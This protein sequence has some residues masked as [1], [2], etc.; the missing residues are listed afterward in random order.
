MKPHLVLLFLVTCAARALAQDAVSPD[1]TARF[2]AGLPVR[3]T[4]LEGLSRNPSWVDHAAEFDKAWKELDTRQL[5]KI[6]A[7]STEFLTDAATD[8]GPMFYMFSGPDILYAQVF[9]PNAS[10]YVLA[11]LEPVGTVPDVLHLPPGALSSGLANLRKSMNSVLSFSFFI[12]KDMKVDLHQNQLSGTLPILYVFLE[13]AGCKLDSVDLVWLDKTGTLSTTKASTPGVKIV[14]FGPSGAQQ[15]L[16]YF[17]TNLANE[18]VKAQPGFLKFCENLAPGRSLLKAASYLMHL[19]DFTTVRDFLLAHS[20]MIV[21]DDSGI[22]IK[23]FDAAKWS[24]RY[25]GSYPGP[26]DM[27]KKNTQPELATIYK[28]SHPPAL[29]FGFGYRWHSSQSSLILAV[30][31]NTSGDNSTTTK[32]ATPTAQ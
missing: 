12:T 10:T 4:P 32:P 21:E 8:K 15:T 23:E 18:G 31:K 20:S 25:F 28:T 13:R 9:Y 30:P 17:E 3:D 19:S 1:T 11:G 7:W 6:R 27:F 16:Y 22:P 26:I 24:V 5:A 14:F 2:L 29:P